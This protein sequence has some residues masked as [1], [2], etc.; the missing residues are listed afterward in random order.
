MFFGGCERKLSQS[1]FN[2]RA[3]GRGSLPH[4]WQVLRGGR[5]SPATLVEARTL[6]PSDR[7]CTSSSLRGERLLS[8]SRVHVID[9][10]GR[11]VRVRGHDFCRVK[12]FR[13]RRIKVKRDQQIHGSSKLVGLFIRQKLILYSVLVP[14]INECNTFAH[15][16][17]S[18]GETKAVERILCP[19]TTHVNCKQVSL[20]QLAPSR[21]L[22]L[23]DSPLLSGWHHQRRKRPLLSV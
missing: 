4:R 19:P 23:S 10:H 8:T 3:T 12:Q 21:Q 1:S 5:R 18:L 13:K 7:L 2:N 9:W 6:D 17:R 14:G 20:W 16:Q 15:R 11:Q 22:F